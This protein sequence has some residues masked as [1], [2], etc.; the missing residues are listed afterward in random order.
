MRCDGVATAQADNMACG[1]GQA[2][3]RTDAAQKLRIKN[4]GRSGKK[5]KRRQ[6]A[7]EGEGILSSIFTP[8]TMF[9]PLSQLLT[10]TN[11]RWFA[12]SI[13]RKNESVSQ[14]FGHKGKQKKLKRKKKHEKFT[15]KQRKLQ[16]FSTIDSNPPTKRHRQGKAEATASTATRLWHAKVWQ[17]TQHAIGKPRPIIEYMNVRKDPIQR[18]YKK[19]SLHCVPLRS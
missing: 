3:Q 19:S 14:L 8:P 5:P 11:T 6:K 10:P 12:I 2:A 15:A 18:S 9:L 13:C 16:H 1:H 7:L 4:K 17:S